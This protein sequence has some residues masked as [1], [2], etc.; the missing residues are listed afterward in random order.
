MDARRR[1]AIAADVDA[2]LQSLHREPRVVAAR[3][4]PPADADLD[5]PG[6]YAW[7]VDEDGAVQLTA[8][9]GVAF[10]AGQ[11]Y[12]GQ[13]GATKWPSGKVGAS[14]LRTRIGRNHLAGT[15]RAST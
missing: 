6:L 1:A 4:W 11:I 3:E 8:G 10:D 2:D 7:W 5:V 14:T 9:L 13:T 15:V 12:A